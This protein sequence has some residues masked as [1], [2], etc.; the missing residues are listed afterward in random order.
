MGRIILRWLCQT[1]WSCFPTGSHVSKW[2]LANGR[3]HVAVKKDREDQNNACVR[4]SFV[5]Q[6]AAAKP[7]GLAKVAIGNFQRPCIEWSRNNYIARCCSIEL[8]ESCG[9]WTLSSPWPI[10]NP[11]NQLR[12]VRSRWIPCLE[13]VRCVRASSGHGIW[14]DRAI[15]VLQPAKCQDLFIPREFLPLEGQ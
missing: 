6:A 1:I 10:T 11:H 7:D 2:N 4:T 9:A 3:R 8:L 5:E 12:C 14:R 13:L 15:T